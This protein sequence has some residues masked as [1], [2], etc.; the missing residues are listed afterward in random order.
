[1]IMLLGGCGNMMRDVV[2]YASTGIA[3]QRQYTKGAPSTRAYNLTRMSLNFVNR[4]ERKLL[5]SGE[6]I[7]DT[8]RSSYHENTTRLSDISSNYKF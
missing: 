4:A 3:S 6:I 7:D 5:T 1:M 8:T 2:V